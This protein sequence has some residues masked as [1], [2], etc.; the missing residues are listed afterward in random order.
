MHRGCVGAAHQHLLSP[1]SCQLLWEGRC[2]PPHSA[3]HD[4]Q[5]G[6]PR[7]PDTGTWERQ[8]Q[9]L[10]SPHP[11]DPT[12]GFTTRGPGGISPSH[13]HPEWHCTKTQAWSRAACSAPSRHI[14]F[15]HF[16]FIISLRLFILSSGLQPQKRGDCDKLI[17]TPPKP[18]LGWKCKCTTRMRKGL[19]DEASRGHLKTSN[20][21]SAPKWCFAPP[22]IRPWLNSCQMERKGEVV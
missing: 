17:N 5:P 15:L 6:M 19:P 8:Q 22:E 7:S 1:G 20:C 16:K 2:S 12:A 11:Q 18:F 21:S 4:G 14:F 9:D 10:L 13:E 3:G